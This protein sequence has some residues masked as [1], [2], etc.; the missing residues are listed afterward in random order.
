M[1]QLNKYTQLKIK[2]DKLSKTLFRLR[3]ALNTSELIEMENNN[4]EL[5]HCLYLLSLE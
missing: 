1:N 3:L 5:R 2:A 4:D